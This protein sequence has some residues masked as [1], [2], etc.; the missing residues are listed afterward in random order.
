M[1][2]SLL[3]YLTA[4]CGDAFASQGLSPDFGRV[5]VSDRP[6]LAP[7]QCNGALSA[8]KQAGK[9]PRAIAEAIVAI[10]KQDSDFAALELAG[11]GFINI[12][13]SDAV[14]ARF[15]TDTA[16]DTRLGTPVLGNGET[17]V[18][19]Y[20]GPNVA[21]PMHVGHL[22]SGIIGDTVRRM[23]QDTG[24]KTLGD[25]HMGDWGTQ[26]G[27]IISELKR[28]SPELPYFDPHFTGPYPAE[29]PVTMEDLEEI[30]PAASAACK[31]DPARLEEAQLATVELQNKRAGYYALWRHFMDVSIVSMKANYQTLNVEFDLWKGEA[32]VHDLIEPMVKDLQARHIAIDSD[33]AVVIPVAKNDDAK[34][35][36]PLI[37]YKRDGAVMYGTTDL[38]TLVERQLLYAPARVIY[39]VDQ[40]QGLHFEQLFRA[41]YKS[42]IIPEAVELT[43]AGFGTMNGADGKPFKTRAGGVMKLEDLI[44][45]AM[46]KAG[47]RLQEANIGQDYSTEEQT[48]IARKV[49]VS[50]IKFADLQNN[51]VA[52][53]VFD[54]DRLT[55]FEGKTGPY[56]LYQTVRMNSLLHKVGES[57]EPAQLVLGGPERTLALA[58][59]DWPEAF[60][61]AVRGYAPH[62]ICDYLY[63][64]AQTFSSFYAAC[65]ILPE[66]DPDIRATRLLLVKLTHAMLTR[67]LGLLGIDVPERM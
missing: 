58:L 54:L 53:Y 44:A 49:A 32:D 27:M 14:I 48:D 36:P 21:K 1:G 50:A 22:R 7:F 23:M 8:A 37:L 59:L 55:Q 38:A 16:A 47:A 26:M 5:Q 67:S 56:L 45:M 65:P 18:L 2:Q 39:I 12:H 30:Y 35:Y 33:G 43:H 62:I 11:P 52:D 63:R 15:L 25:I 31:A 51:R 64:L 10:L 29:S 34:E 42:G 46:E 4:K 17:V 61:G 41:A 9:P 60:S 20:G 57:A 13:L 40:R 19:D 3:S 28:R 24:F 6:D 66:K